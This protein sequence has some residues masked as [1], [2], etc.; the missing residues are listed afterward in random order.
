MTPKTLASFKQKGKTLPTRSLE[1]S[2]KLMELYSKGV[3]LFGEQIH[4]TSWL[5]KE[6]YGLGGR[7]PI[8]LLNTVSGTDLVYEELLRI[9]FGATA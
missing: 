4:F 1:I 6:S 8:S 7:K 2:I 3:E 5:Q 9:E